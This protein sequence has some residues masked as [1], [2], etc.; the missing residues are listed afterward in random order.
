MTKKWGKSSLFLSLT[1]LLL[2]V[3][4]IVGFSIFAIARSFSPGRVGRPLQPSE[5]ADVKA[6]ITLMLAR[7]LTSQAALAAQLD[8]R[9]I[10]QA[11]TP[12]DPYLK[13][14]EKA[15]D[16]PFAYTLSSGHHPSAIVLAPRF[17]TETTPTAR[18]A[19]MIHEM[20]HYSAYVKTGSS[21]E[22]DGY[23]AEYNTHKQLG[24]TDA[25]GLTYFAMLDGVVEYVVPRLPVYKTY[26]DVEAYIK[27][28]S[29]N[30]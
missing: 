30:D 13:M 11:A 12:S 24:L 15:G 25:D 10:W 9:G 2:I 22:Y 3:A 26:P 7:G 19:L 6:A 27:E 5:A 23:K 16:T 17:F 4:A 8:K 20:G 1:A 28:S 29:D 14:A 21:T 18:A